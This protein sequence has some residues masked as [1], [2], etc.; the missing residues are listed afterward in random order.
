MR[1]QNYPDLYGR[2][3][4]N[5]LR[6]LWGNPPQ[7]RGM[8]TGEC[9]QQVAYLTVEDLQRRPAR[10]PHAVRF[11]EIDKL[12]R[13]SGWELARIEGGHHIYPSGGRLFVVPYRRP[14]LLTVYVRVALK[15]TRVPEDA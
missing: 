13:L 14:H 7:G 9:E 1:V 11:E 8:M 3:S 10:R 6:P 12:P 5:I 4:G 15:L 2:L